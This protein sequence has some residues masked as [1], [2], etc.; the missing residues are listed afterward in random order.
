MYLLTAVRSNEC[1]A[2]KLALGYDWFSLTAI[3]EFQELFSK[4]FALRVS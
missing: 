3:V 2:E 4:F 1:A